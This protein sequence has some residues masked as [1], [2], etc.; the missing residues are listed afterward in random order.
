GTRIEQ[1]T[2]N[3]DTI[4][5]GSPTTTASGVVL[6]HLVAIGVR[7]DGSDSGVAIHCVNC[8]HLQL[9]GIVGTQAHDGLYFDSAYGHAYDA[10][11]TD[12][13]FTGNDYGVHIVGGSANRLTFVGNTVDAN[14]YGVFDDGGWQHTWI[15][16]DIE[17]N[18]RYGYWQQVSDPQAWSGHNVVLH[19]NYFEDN[20]STSGQGDVFLGQLVAGGGPQGN[21]GAGCI[22]CEVTDN[23]FNASPDGS[24]TA[25]NLGAVTMTV[26]DNTYSGYGAGKVYATI[27]GPAPNY[28][29]VLV[30]GDCGTITSS[31]GCAR[32]QPN[33]ITQMG[34]GA[35]TIGGTDQ[36]TD[37]YGTE[38]HD[39]TIESPTGVVRV[40]GTPG[41]A[42][43]NNPA[44]L[45]LDGNSTAS[46]VDEIHFRNRNVDAWG[47]RSDVSGNGSHDFCLANDYAIPSVATCDLYLN[48]QKH[49]KFSAAG[50]P[51]NVA[52]YG[53]YN[54]LQQANGDSA[55]VINR[56]T[57][58]SPTGYLLD[59][60]DTSNSHPLFRVDASGNVSTSGT[61]NVAGAATFQSSV[62]AAAGSTVGGKVINTDPATVRA[63]SDTYWSGSYGPGSCDSGTVSIASGVSIGMVVQAT[64]TTAPPAG[65]LWNS[66]ISGANQVTVRVCNVTGATISWGNGTA[67]QIAIIP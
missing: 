32:S 53:D 26:R 36:L 38:L 22:N 41:G 48:Q 61:L 6:E 55:V 35:L 27:T 65:L 56:A 34:Y 67:F 13:H 23:S 3:T 63:S 7:G 51:G 54:F 57:D 46:A 44:E 58:V 52:L 60:E 14:A 62:A 29:R 17:S 20:G 66:Y 64:P 10:E 59:V 37:Q 5:V 2:P 42:M 4:Q 9:S 24:V 16:N 50:V 28:S 11:V 25:L 33:A 43:A 47:I 19:G 15:G 12:S 49:F 1:Q 40:R 21:N 39:T 8:V 30:L 31:S 45:Y 18:S